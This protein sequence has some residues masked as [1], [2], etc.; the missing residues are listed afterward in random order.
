[1]CFFV[2]GDKTSCC[3]LS[4]LRNILSPY[5]T[6]NRNF[7]AASRHKLLL[8]NSCKLNYYHPICSIIVVNRTFMSTLQPKTNRSISDFPFIKKAGDR[9]D[10]L[11]L[12]KYS[13]NI[14]NTRHI[15]T[16]HKL[17][18]NDFAHKTGYRIS[19]QK[20]RNK[21]RTTTQCL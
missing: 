20:F 6:L 15:N 11:L 8:H 3:C 10:Y 19:E 13:T 17:K 18:W 14:C 12:E 16:I 4:S 21:T 2:L 7:G 1:M 5:F 9:M